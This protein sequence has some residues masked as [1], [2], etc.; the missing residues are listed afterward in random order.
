MTFIQLL[1]SF[2]ALGVM[3]GAVTWVI[4]VGLFAITSSTRRVFWA[5]IRSDLT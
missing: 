3:L 4:S 1:A 5:C 2:L